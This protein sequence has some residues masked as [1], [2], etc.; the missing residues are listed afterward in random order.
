MR[1]HV[2]LV[3][4]LACLLACAGAEPVT[5]QPTPTRAPP[6]RVAAEEL[7]P[8]PITR[9]LDLGQAR[10]EVSRLA[11]A[12]FTARKD[13]VDAGGKPVATPD[14]PADEFLGGLVGDRWQLRIEPPAG[15]WTRV[16]F[17]RFGE[18]PE[19]EVG[20]ASE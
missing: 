16:S 6:A 11:R 3:S 1:V 19:V 10:Q 14:F 12:A 8:D 15:A 18:R 9:P 17:G 5:A 7:I 20:F 4:P 2:C 13:I